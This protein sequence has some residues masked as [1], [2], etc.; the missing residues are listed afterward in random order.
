VA[1]RIGVAPQPR[2]GKPVQS[3]IVLGN[4]AMG[5]RGVTGKIDTNNGTS[6]AQTHATIVTVN[7]LLFNLR[8]L[9]GELD[10]FPRVAAHIEPGPCGDI[11]AADSVSS[12][13][14]RSST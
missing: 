4:S 13:V 1:W 2:A 14:L 8:D 7:H 5:R 6:D 12:D 10:V 11:A 3:S 9:H